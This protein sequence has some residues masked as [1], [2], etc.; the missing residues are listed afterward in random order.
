MSDETEVVEFNKYSDHF[1]HDK[2][3]W[4]YSAL[5]NEANLRDLE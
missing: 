3:G 1:D 2:T 4:Y 5:S